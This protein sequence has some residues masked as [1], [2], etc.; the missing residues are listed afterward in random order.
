MIKPF[1]HYIMKNVSKTALVFSLL[2]GLIF[3]L[4]YC[5]Q[6]D[7]IIG[8]DEPTLGANVLLAQKVTT[9]PTIDGTI[10]GVWESSAKLEFETVV[11]DPTG[12]AF[13]GYVGNVIPFVR[14]R[15]AYDAN[16]IYFLAEWDDPTESLVRQPWYFDPTAKLWKQ[17]SGAPTFTTPTRAAFYEDKIAMLWN[18]NN[19]VSGW[20]S[21]TCYKSCHTSLSAADGFARHYTNNSSERI[22][23]WHWKSVR[24]GVNAG[25]FD[26]QY[27][28]NTYPNGRKSDAGASAYTDNKQNLV[29][30]G[31]SPAVTVAVPKYVIPGRTKYYWIL[32]AE[33]DN[34]TAKLITSVDANG[35]LTLSDG[36]IID[37]NTDVAYQR[38]G[39]G[40]GDKV[41]AGINVSS[42]DGSRGDITCKSTFTG[43]GW[44]LEFKRALKTGDTEKKDVDFS[45]LDDQ[46]FGFAIFENAQIAHGLKP[47]LL[48]K[49]QK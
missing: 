5:R 1:K 7:Q 29:V 46:Y 43:T 44:I 27:Q 21:A 9:A 37:P 12:D 23:M 36:T 30:T 17:E 6:D 33:I 35:V 11:P 10:D 34:G 18:I 41:I 45:S 3:I 26:D 40:L 2:A 38:A 31:S 19:S 24:G 32:G 13:R 20:N 15:A 47:N 49:F 42:Y 22:D 4:S 39:A 48:L 28:D 25:Q 14:L 8:V 16:S